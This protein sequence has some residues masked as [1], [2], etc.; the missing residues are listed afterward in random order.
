MT[1]RR[2]QTGSIRK[3]GKRHPVWELQWWADYLTAEGKIGRKR[4]SSILGYVADLTRK[5]AQKLAAEELLPLNQGKLTPM[6]TVTFGE[7]VERFFVPNA[8][9]SL[10]QSTRKRYRSTINFH[11]KPAFGQ[12]RL[13]DISTLDIQTFVLSK[14]D[15]GSGW[16]VCNHL[17]NLMSKVFASAKKWGHFAGDNPA[18]G[19]DLPEKVAV[20]ER[21]ALTPE[22]SKRLLAALPEPVRTMALTG[23]VAGLRVGEIL[24]L[25]WQDVDFL[26]RSIRIQQAAYRGSIGSP[27]T[28]GSKRTLPLPESLY[29]AL[30]RHYDAS[31]Q[32]DGLVFPTRTGMPFSDSNL[33]ARHLKPVGKQIGTPW[34]GWHTLRR[35][36]ATLLSQAGASPKD[37]QAQL[38]HAHMSTTMDIYTQLT[39]THQRAAVERMSQLVMNGDELAALQGAPQLET[40]CIQ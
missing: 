39:P 16:E 7:F 36:H 12:K 19:V 27:K 38:G 29:V 18:T 6:A 17:R 34:I 21:T 23:I 11:L 40:L 35:T 22:Q 15:T 8:L 37:A 33:L 30:N 26:N 9:P 14:F 3:R 1:R 5:Q 20:H 13:C 31:V 25:R 10:K 28:K 4:E 32:R 2:Y 24:G